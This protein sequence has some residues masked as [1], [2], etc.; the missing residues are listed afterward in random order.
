VRPC[1]EAKVVPSEVVE[2][3]AVPR[4]AVP[5]VTLVLNIRMALQ[6]NYVG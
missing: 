6:L 5:E 3:Q 2:G 4:E 1:T